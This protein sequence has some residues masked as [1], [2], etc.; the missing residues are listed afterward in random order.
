MY[1]VWIQVVMINV[2]VATNAAEIVQMLCKTN[3]NVTSLIISTATKFVF[4]DISNI[5]A[6]Q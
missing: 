4:Y 2:N 3:F 5:Q 6:K 1:T